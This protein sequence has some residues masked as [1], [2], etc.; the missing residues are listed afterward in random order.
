MHRTNR[1]IAAIL[2]LGFCASL[3]LAQQAP[4][5]N[6][7]PSKRPPMGYV[8]VWHFASTLK[9]KVALSLEGPSKAILARAMTP[10]QNMNYR[11]VSPGTYK[12]KIRAARADLD[13]NDKDPELIP[14]VALTVADKTFQ[15]LILQD[16][17]SAPK[18]LAIN[19]TTV[20]SGIP[21][22]GK[23]LRIFHFAAGQDASLTVTPTNEVIAA[24]LTPGISQHLFSNNPGTLMLVMSNKLVNGHNAEQAVELN[25]ASTDSISAI[26]MFDPYGRLAI[27]CEEDARPN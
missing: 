6:E 22:G 12:V 26:V 23:R 7:P 25:F 21:R 16:D 10:G 15:T 24:H 8:R 14:A 4:P 17:G 20:G 11:E 19:D 9:P 3:I 5:V 13:V 27:R 18:I 2:I 1:S